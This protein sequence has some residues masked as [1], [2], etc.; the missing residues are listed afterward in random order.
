MKSDRQNI[1]ALAVIILAGAGLFVGCNHPT[2]VDATASDVPVFAKH[3]K[4]TCDPMDEV[5]DAIVEE[6]NAN[7]PQTEPYRNWGQE[8]SCEKEIIGDILD[9]YSGCFSGEELKLIRQSVF[10]IRNGPAGDRR[11]GDDRTPHELD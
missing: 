7:C 4:V 9:Y 5:I 1:A 2:S 6:L 10:V 8:N 3:P 11:E